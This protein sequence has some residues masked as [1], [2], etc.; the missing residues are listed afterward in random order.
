MFQNSKVNLILRIVCLLT[1][2]LVIIF[3]HSFIT[4]SLLTIFFYLFTRNEKDPLVFWWYIIPILTY[5]FS[6]FT[7]NF[8][9]LKIVLITGLAYYFIVV[10]NKEDNI[11]EKRILTIDKYFIRFKNNKKR[12]DVID[13]NLVNAIYVTVHL[14]ILFITIMVGY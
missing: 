14:F 12:K 6:Y 8:Y 13:M 9:I 11:V 3:N 10:P 1:Y 7:D 5:L 4:L 2:S